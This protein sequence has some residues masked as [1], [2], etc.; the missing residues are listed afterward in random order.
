[1]FSKLSIFSAFIAL[2]AA[3]TIP[4]T[5][6]TSPQ[7]CSSVVQSDSIEA[8][9][10]LSALGINLGDTVSSSLSGSAAPRSRFWESVVFSFQ[11]A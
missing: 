11:I 5:P 9:E 7:C 4:V 8:T 3:T 6:P 1:M 2:A 10:V